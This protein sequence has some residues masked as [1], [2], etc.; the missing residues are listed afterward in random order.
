MFSRSNLFP[1]FSISGNSMPYISCSKSGSVSGFLVLSHSF[2]N[3]Q[4]CISNHSVPEITV[5]LVRQTAHNMHV[6]CIAS[7]IHV[8]KNSNNALTTAGFTPCLAHAII[9]FSGFV[10][11]STNQCM[12]G[13]F[14]IVMEPDLPRGH[15][16]YRHVRHTRS[17]MS[18]SRR[19]HDCTR[20]NARCLSRVYIVIKLHYITCFQFDHGCLTL[21]LQL[22]CSWFYSVLVDMLRES[23]DT[24]ESFIDLHVQP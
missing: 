2:Q 3:V 13:Y 24:D 14:D 12:F 15:S 5:S 21:Q 17:G 10:T 23:Q 9:T 16:G 20:C 11:V 22:L 8:T 18:S 7:C 1:F 6:A 4:S 19:V